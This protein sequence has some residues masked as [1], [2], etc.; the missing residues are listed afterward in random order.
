MP[1]ASKRQMAFFTTTRSLLPRGLRRP[2]FAFSADGFEYP[3][4]ATSVAE[5]LRLTN[6]ADRI[7]T[8]QARIAEHRRKLVMFY[9]GGRDPIAGR[10]YIERWSEIAG[11]GARAKRHRKTRRDRVG[12][13]FAPDRTPPHHRLL[14]RSGPT[15]GGRSRAVTALRYLLDTLH[16]PWW[17]ES[18]NH[19]G[20]E[21]DII[22]RF[23]NEDGDRLAGTQRFAHPFV[24]RYVC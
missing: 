5:A 6:L 19:S 7:A 12:R 22:G 13:D 15:A 1:S 11:A 18:S 21:H 14:D 16:V 3:V 9:G 10:P 24:H 23:M 17:L 2:R 8:I 20:F 4:A